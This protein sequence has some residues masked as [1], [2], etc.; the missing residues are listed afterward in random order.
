MFHSYV[1]HYQRV[2]LMSPQTF[3]GSVNPLWRHKQPM[4]AQSG[5]RDV[6]GQ[7]AGVPA[8]LF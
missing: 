8:R 5:Q 6:L 3:L 7:Q 2:V 1:S 4:F